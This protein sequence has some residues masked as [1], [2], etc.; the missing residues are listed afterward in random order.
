MK[1]GSVFTASIVFVL[2]GHGESSFLVCK[3]PPTVL[4]C[5]EGKGRKGKDS[6]AVPTNWRRTAIA[7]TFS[8]C[9]TT[10]SQHDGDMLS[11]FLWAKYFADSLPTTLSEGL[12]DG[13]LR[14]V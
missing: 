4:E 12:N 9:L 2:F 14:W 13:T 11:P 1:V 5:V 10:Q 3:C 6:M 7:E 8:T